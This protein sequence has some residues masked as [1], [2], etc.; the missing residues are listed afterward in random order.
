MSSQQEMPDLTRESAPQPELADSLSGL[1]HATRI[2]KN[3]TIDDVA[4]TTKYSKWQLL[5]LEDKNWAAL[6]EGFILRSIVRKYAEA[7]SIDPDVALELLSRE[8][9][10]KPK[11]SDSK[12]LV[13]S[14]DYKMSPTS[15]DKAKTRG[16]SIS[17]IIWL[18]LLVAII[19]LGIALWQEAITL[20]DLNLGFVRDWFDAV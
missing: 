1:L 3:L 20:E 7:L 14:L 12:N 4:N 17:T 19:V 16:F 8:T 18:L 13:S 9:G 6:P 10:N 15:T 11:N 5:A 2:R